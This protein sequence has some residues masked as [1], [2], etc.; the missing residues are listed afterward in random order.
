MTWWSALSNSLWIIGLAVVLSTCS[1]AYYRTQT[2]QIPLRQSLGKAGFQL[3]LNSGMT[4]FCLGMLFGGQSWWEKA[5]WAVLAALFAVQ[6]VYTWLKKTG[7][8]K[9]NQPE[10]SL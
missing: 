10:S 1:L 3:A 6:V 2:I 9:I 4:L 5:I 8:T 7:K